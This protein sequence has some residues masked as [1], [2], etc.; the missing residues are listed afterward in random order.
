M[1]KKKKEKETKK[2]QMKTPQHFPKGDTSNEGGITMATEKHEC[3]P[4][5][6]RRLKLGVASC[7]ACCVPGSPCGSQGPEVAGQQVL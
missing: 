5:L 7:P 1:Q 6:G 4:W 3:G 2:E